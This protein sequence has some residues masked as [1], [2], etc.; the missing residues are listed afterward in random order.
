[1]GCRFV[2]AKQ[3]CRIDCGI[4]IYIYKVVISKPQETSD[5]ILATYCL[6]VCFYLVVVL[7]RTM[8]A[9]TIAW[10][11]THFSFSPSYLINFFIFIWMIVTS[12]FILDNFYFLHY[13]FWKTLYVVTI[14]EF[15][16]NTTYTR[17]VNILY[18][19]WI[20]TRICPYFVDLIS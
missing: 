18:I 17:I 3:K 16:F 9:C 8:H 2:H 20:F 11:T 6:V 15:L 7:N 10:I 4:I 1:M 14:N 12:H 19:W 13:D 5:E